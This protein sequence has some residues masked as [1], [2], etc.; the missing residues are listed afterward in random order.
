M[1]RGSLIVLALLCCA[2]ATLLAIW[3]V[4]PFYPLWTVALGASEWGLWLTILALVG[5]FL[6]VAA[7][8]LG[9]RWGLIA[10]LVLG[11]PGIGLGLLP[12]AQ[13]LPVA[14]QHEARLSLSRYLWGWRSPPTGDAPETVTFANVDGRPLMLDVYRSAAASSGVRPAI[15]VVH[16]GSWSAGDKSDFPQWNYWLT[17]QGY[18]IFDVQYRLAPQPNW[19]TAT[20]DV[21]CAVGWVRE[22]AAEYGVDPARIALL[23]RSA[24]AHLALLAGYS[25]DES[26]LP[27]SCATGDTTVK[28]VV[29]FYGPTDL[30]WGYNATADANGENGS[31]A[32]ERLLG[33]TPRTL[34]QEYAL[35]SPV[36]HVRATTP[37]T[38][39]LHGGRDQLVSPLHST[40][41]VER[42]RAANVAYDT[43]DIPYG[44][45]GFDYNFNGWSGQ[46]VRPVLQRFLERYL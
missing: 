41:L 30:A 44:Q 33:G 11:L 13:A 38:L 23:G 12:L 8:A 14:R 42:L 16:G 27:P 35:S 46:I 5:I 3:I 43:V 29:E 18:T 1:L 28:L 39:L 24:G 36:T 15:V 7:R 32:T 40:M 2:S 31:P 10:A 21:K 17:A 19:Q 6:G 37:P 34:P 45:H 9:S 22:H 25:A 4:I 20:G 26:V